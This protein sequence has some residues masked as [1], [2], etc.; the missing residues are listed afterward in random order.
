MTYVEVMPSFS[1]HRQKHI[2]IACMTLH[3]FIHD[4]P[5]RD[6]EFDKCDEDEDYMPQDEDDNEVQ[7]VAQPIKYDIHDEEN[8]IFMNTV[9]DNIA[10]VLISGE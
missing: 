10:N 6:E 7:E 3:N 9:R 8:E 1:S 5:L 2:I 4:I